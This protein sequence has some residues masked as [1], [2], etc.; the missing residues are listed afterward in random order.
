M[1][2][3]VRTILECVGED[4]DRPGLR[5]TPAR[6]AKA[7]L[8]MTRGYAQT[9]AEVVG[10][11][12]F[13]CDDGGDGDSGMVVVKDIAF[14][15]MCE[16]HML[17]FFGRVHVA[18]IPKPAADG[19]KVV[20]I[21]KIARLAEV[22]ARRLQI[23]ERFSSQLAQAVMD[24]VDAKGVAVM[25]EATHMCMVM[26]GVHKPGS[27]TVTRAMRGAFKGREGAELRREF[28]SYVRSGPSVA[29]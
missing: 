12:L 8:E 24:T 22:F 4:P 5:K 1:E 23:Q 17:P 13:D 29:V 28:L 11:A 19:G 16:H 10:D 21:S 18:Y 25:A 6:V 15:T 7:M 9:P 3:A 14:H 20:G 2:G 27:L 26:R